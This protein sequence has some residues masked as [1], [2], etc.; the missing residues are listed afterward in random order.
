MR[1]R[2]ADTFNHDADAPGYDDDVVDESQPVR[3]GYSALLDWVART[4]DIQ[5]EHRVLELGAGTGNLTRLL[6][7]A[8]RIVAVDVSTEM[9]ALARRKIDLP[10]EW[11]EDDLL[12]Y[13]D[14]DVG[15]FD[16]FVSTYAIHHL[17]ADEKTE[18]FRSIRR[19]A[20]PG[21]RAVFGDLMFESGAHREGA[22]RRYRPSQPD[23]A[24]A[25]EQEFFWFVDD[26]TT[27]L[28]QLGFRVESRQFS[29]LSWGIAAVLA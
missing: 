21:A 20:A 9:L 14:R 2:H 17:V 8:I 16:R 26:A 12:G 3:S 5:A 6:P 29:D 22:L 11:I 23:V 10:V 18:L 15:S 25:I 19:H 7:Q 4:A 24:E 28:T 1:S 13:F 27:A